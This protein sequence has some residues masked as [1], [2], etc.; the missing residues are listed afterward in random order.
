MPNLLYRHQMAPGHKGGVYSLVGAPVSS[1]SSTPLPPAPTL[2]VTPTKTI[3]DPTFTALAGWTYAVDPSSFRLEGSLDGI[4][5]GPVDTPGGADRSLEVSL[6]TGDDEYYRIFAIVSGVDS[7]PSNVVLVATA[8]TVASATITSPTVIAVTSNVTETPISW[9]Y[10]EDGGTTFTV[11]SLATANGDLTVPDTLLVTHV[12]VSGTFFD[13]DSHPTWY[14]EPFEVVFNPLAIAGLETA[15]DWTAIYNAGQMWQDALKT[16]PTTL[17]GQPIAVFIDTLTGLE[18]HVTSTG[19]AG[20]LTDRGGGLWGNTFAVSGPTGYIS[21]G[22]NP[23]G[24]VFMSVRNTT[25]NTAGRVMASGSKN[26]LMHQRRNDGVC[27]F[28]AGGNIRSTPIVA[29]A[30]L[31]TV[32]CQKAS[33]GNWIMFLDGSAVA[34]SDANVPTEFGEIATGS[35]NQAGGESFDGLMVSF[36][37]YNTDISSGNRALIESWMASR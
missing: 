36:V 32:T 34:L 27:F 12:E 21:S 11:A 33:G 22:L 29:D 2:T 19:T 15:W 13:A 17:D 4:T 9:Q 14:S 30:A 20:L 23:T 28:I 8:P 37:V 31:H 35:T 10:S 16:I 5:W 6:A 24:D 1:G 26:A 7:L 18:W 3:T 25:T